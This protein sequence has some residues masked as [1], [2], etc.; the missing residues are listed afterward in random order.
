MAAAEGTDWGPL[1]TE[2]GREFSGEEE[3]ARGRAWPR[4]P[5]EPGAPAWVQG[6]HRGYSATRPRGA[7]DS[8]E[9]DGG[10]ARDLKRHLQGRGRRRTWGEGPS[11]GAAAAHP[12]VPFPT[13]TWVSQAASRV[14]TIVELGKTRRPENVAW[15]KSKLGRHTASIHSHPEKL[16]RHP[17]AGWNLGLRRGCP[18]FW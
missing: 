2:Q 14:L 11:A 5:Q 15:Q 8:P 16:Q 12:P 18:R 7:G 10:A 3:H 6:G 4:H 17:S 9:P 1:V 13:P